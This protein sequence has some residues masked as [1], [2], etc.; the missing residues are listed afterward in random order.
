MLALTVVLFLCPTAGE[1]SAVICAR[2]FAGC[3]DLEIR[4]QIL[5]TC[6]E[7]HS[8]VIGNCAIQSCDRKNTHNNKYWY[9]VSLLKV[10]TTHAPTVIMEGVCISPACLSW[11][12]MSSRVA[13]ACTPSVWVL[14]RPANDFFSE[15]PQTWR[16]TNCFGFKLISKCKPLLLLHHYYNYN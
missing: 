13:S 5:P 16:E 14:S 8:N 11:W 6:F 10:V 1:A 7:S 12:V 9:S 3:V 15:A 2:G 4:L